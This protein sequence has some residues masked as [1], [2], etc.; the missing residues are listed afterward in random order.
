MKMNPNPVRVARQIC[1]Q[2][3][4]LAWLHCRLAGCY[5]TYWVVKASQPKYIYAWLALAC[6]LTMLNGRLAHAQAPLVDLSRGDTGQHGARVPPDLLLNLSLTH[7][8]AG[9]VYQQ[10]YRP[11]DSYAGYFDARMCYSYPLRSQEGGQ[12]PDLRLATAYFSVLKRAAPQHDCGGDSFSGNFLNWASTSMVDIVRL[13]LSGG[14]RVIDEA[15]K[16]VL[17]RAYLPA[18]NGGPDFFAHA[19]YFPRKLLLAGVAAATPFGVA[20]LSVISCRNRLLFGDGAL[21]LAGTCDA[22]GSAAALGVY[23]ARV[24]VCDQTEG[25]VRPDLCMAYGKQYKP[26][27]ALQ[28]HGE[29]VRIGVFGAWNMPADSADAAVYGGAMRAPLAHIAGQRWLAPA[30]APQDNPYAAWQRSTGVTMR[31][32]SSV[33]GAAIAPINTLGRSVPQQLGHYA[34]GAPLA[35][36]LYESLRY[37]QGR[38]PSAA[39]TLHNDGLPLQA[40]WSDPQQAA[41]QRHAVLTLADAGMA[42]DWF[43]PGNVPGTTA[44]AAGAGSRARGADAY[45][46]PPFD[47]MAW[48]GAVGKL[49]SAG[50]AAAPAAAANGL[51]RQF[52][53]PHGASYYAAGLAYWSH[54]RPIRPLAV[55]DNAAGAA[56]LSAV[57][58]TTADLQPAN[59]TMPGDLPVTPLLLAARYGGD[60]DAAS[61]GRPFSAPGDAASAALASSWRSASRL[62]HHY[63]P[64]NNPAALIAGLHELVLATDRAT[65]VPALPGPSLLALADGVE[66]A[67]WFDTRMRLDDGSMQLARASFALGTDGSVTPGKVW[68]RSGGVLPET[69]AGGAGAGASGTLRPVHTPDGQGGLLV[70]DWPRLSAQQRSWFQRDDEADE[71]SGM[72]PGEARVRYLQGERV[73]EVDQPGGFLRRRSSTLGAAPHGSIVYVGAPALNRAGAGYLLHR[74]HMLA[75]PKML[76]AGAND[77]LLHAFDAVSGKELFAYLPQALLTGV[78]KGVTVTSGLT[79]DGGPM[80]D[81]AAAHAEVLLR[82]RWRTVLVSGMGGGAQGLFALDVT[83]PQRFSQEGALWEF[84]DLDDS[85]MGNLRAAP[86]VARIN[87]GGKSGARAYREFAVVSSGYNN[88]QQDGKTR[89]VARPAAAIFLLALDKPPREQW[90]LNSNYFRLAVPAASDARVAEA[91]AALASHAL[92]PPTLVA[93]DD[94][95]LAYI[96]AGDMQGNIWRLD[97]AAGPPWQE[98]AGRKLVFV[99]RDEQGVRQAITQQ[100]KVAYAPGGGYLLLFG[101]GKLIEPA[102]MWPAAFVPQ[103]LYAVRDDLKEES[104]TR[105]RLDLVPRNLTASGKGWRVDGADLRYAGSG[106]LH[107]WVLDLADTVLGGERS[108]YSPVLAAGMA[109]FNT[110]LPG[111]DACAQ[112]ATRLYALEVASGFAADAAGTIRPDAVTG[113]LLDGAGL[114]RA[115]PQLL[116]LGRSASAP[117]AAGRADGRKTFAVV[118]PGVSGGSALRVVSGALPVGRLS[119]REIANWRELHEAAKK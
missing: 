19:Q 102:D 61:N 80:L 114:A 33:A 37:L 115:P 40:N 79:Y 89:S 25:A 24:Q 71:A 81:G 64:G 59:S 86:S 93:G 52:Y 95:A 91:N 48:T 29:R 94:G 112:P 36:I 88:T 113:H 12:L 49:E 35:E 41:C 38:Q 2:L 43:V 26:V 14:D 7:V 75:R 31:P 110:V 51:E 6:L 62:P 18:G 82:G 85:L 3:L 77:G 76:Y 57:A 69:K 100:I 23:L 109:V 27:G 116:E 17:Q 119:W 11:Q 72:S 70:L 10:P 30:F 20:K 73:H 8:A 28:R 67:Y 1:G 46:A 22:P 68:W 106:A 97:L 63:L 50:A 105:S 9:A 66:E 4:H 84:T 44:G 55:N 45:T 47:V 15:A 58:H 108:V 74:Q 32:D 87:M 78:L 5:L 92:A 117:G 54:V 16:T 13:G 96:Y 83:D 104:P 56:I 111:R 99:A 101:T 65:L 90:Q 103:S 42:P 34:S 39:N 53:G 98:G 107:G 21:A 60:G 118:Q